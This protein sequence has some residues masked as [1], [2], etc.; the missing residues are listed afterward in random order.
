M[1]EFY[2][3]I[4][5]SPTQYFRQCKVPIVIVTDEATYVK[6]GETCFTNKTS[7]KTSKI[8]PIDVVRF[9]STTRERQLKANKR[10]RGEGHTQ[11]FY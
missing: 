4:I 2:V 9:C 5:M 1:S 6:G 11:A 3:I 8:T 7:N 10:P